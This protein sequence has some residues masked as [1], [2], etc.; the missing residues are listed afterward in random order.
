MRRA[1]TLPEVLIAILVFTVGI[2]GL[3]ASG[4]FL[5]VQVREADALTRAAVLAG[6]V[7]DSLRATPCHAVT[8]GAATD[9]LAALRW[10]VAPGGRVL[11]VAAELTVAGRRRPW[12]LTLET[13]L[14]CDR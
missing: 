4:T 3:A 6:S 10:T 5:V 7:L 13:L 14:P 8:P 2:L 1:F 11:T 12:H 9:G